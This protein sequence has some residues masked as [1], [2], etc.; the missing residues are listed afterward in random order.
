MVLI[1]L[2]FSDIKNTT[3]TFSNI[4]LFN[5]YISTVDITLKFNYIEIPTF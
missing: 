4:T 1:L 5:S 2:I 3:C